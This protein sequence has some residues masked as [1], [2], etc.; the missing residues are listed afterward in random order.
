VAQAEPS[1]LTPKQVMAETG[2]TRYA[3][4]K[5]LKE[6]VIPAID[7]STAALKR[8]RGHRPTYRVPREALRK[9]LSTQTNI[10]TERRSSS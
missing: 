6:G 8:K 7:I 10:R 9:W 5:L 3:T 4:Y 1:L 2:L